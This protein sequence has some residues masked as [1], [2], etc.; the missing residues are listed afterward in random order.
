MTRLEVL[1][2]LALFH[3]LPSP[4]EDRLEVFRQSTNFTYFLERMR[5]DDRIRDIQTID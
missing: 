4:E 2:Q 1:K 3:V 5:Y